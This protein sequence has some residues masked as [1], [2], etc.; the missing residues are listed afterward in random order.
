MINEILRSYRYFY[1][2]YINY[3]II[4]LISLKEHLIYLRFIFSIFEKINI[5]LSSIFFYSIIKSKN[6][7]LKLIMIEKKF[8]IITNLSFQGFSF[9]SRNISILLNI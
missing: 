8:I 1:R 3:I 6:R 2:F 4:I 9:N 5:H 7:C